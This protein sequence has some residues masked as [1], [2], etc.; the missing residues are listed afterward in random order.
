MC[1]LQ[2]LLLSNI[3]PL[4]NQRTAI[5]KTRCTINGKVCED[6]VD[7][8]SNENVV[9]M[10]LVKAFQLPTTPRPKSYKIGWIKKELT[11]R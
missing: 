1:I 6:V 11:P 10:A 9:S 8:G 7:G 4:P 2:K 3:T 5:F